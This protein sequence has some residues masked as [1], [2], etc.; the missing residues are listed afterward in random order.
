[1]ADLFI[2]KMK[3]SLSGGGARS[4]YFEVEIPGLTLEQ[5]ILVKAASL[6]A[7]IISPIMVPFRGRQLQVAGDR[8]FEPWTITVVNDTD[9]AIRNYFE[10]WMQDINQHVSNI[11]TANPADYMQDA[12]VYQLDRAGARTKGYS[13]KSIWPSN[14]SAVDLSYD[15]ENTISEF[16]VELQVTYWTSEQSGTNV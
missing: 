14:V 11:S 6:P 4:N 15:S 5:N 3:S 12:Q 10:K 13:F 1:M 7:S 16:T 8:T 9:M 2:D